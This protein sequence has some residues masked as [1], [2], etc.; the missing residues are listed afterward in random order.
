MYCHLLCG[1]RNYEFIDGIISP[2]AIGLIRAFSFFESKWEQLCDDLE[3]GYPCLDI[4]EVAMRDSVTEP[5]LK[6]GTRVATR[7]VKKDPINL[8]RK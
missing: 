4:T 8:W 3:N 7:F 1:L 5:D 6:M 2:Y